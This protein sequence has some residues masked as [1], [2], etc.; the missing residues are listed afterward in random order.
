[1]AVVGQRPLDDPVEGVRRDAERLQPRRDPEP[2]VERRDRRRRDRRPRQPH[3]RLEPRIFSAADG[4]LKRSTSGIR[5][6]LSVPWCSFRSCRPP[7]AWL[8]EWTAPRPFWNERPPS[9]APIITSVRASRSSP[10]AARRLEVAARSGRRRRGRSPRRAGCRAA[11]GRS[12]CSA[13]ARRGRSPRSDRA[14]GRAS[15]PGRRSRVSG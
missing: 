9:S 8:S 13:T 5:I 2:P 10:V 14:A 7:S 15:A 4:A 11:T 3:R 12:R 6:A 1:M